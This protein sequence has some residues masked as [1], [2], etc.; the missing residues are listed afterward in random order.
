MVEMSS[1]H[2]MGT[3]R[4]LLG[5]AAVGLLLTGCSYGSGI[6]ATAACKEWAAFRNENNRDKDTD[7]WCDW[8]ATTSREQWLGMKRVGN[9]S[10]VVKH[11][12][13]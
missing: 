13:Y 11:F 6:E 4:F 9:D 3:H 2:C 1:T 10:K 8:E 12:R 5:A 7:Y